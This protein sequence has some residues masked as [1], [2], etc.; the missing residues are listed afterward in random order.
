MTT[1]DYI[2]LIVCFVC[3]GAFLYMLFRWNQGSNPA[4]GKSSDRT[5]A[6]EDKAVGAA[7]LRRK[8]ETWARTH[9]AKVIGP[10]SLNWG[11]KEGSFDFVLVGWFGALGVNCLGYGGTIYGT[12]DEKQWLQ[13][14]NGTRLQFDNPLEAQT[15]SA[16]VL[17]GVLMDGG[18]RGMDVES[19]LVFT[20]PAVELS[21]PRRLNYYS[22]ETF[23]ALLKESRF[24]ADKGVDVEKACQLIEAANTAAKQ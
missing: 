24:A 10:V 21:L 3:V 20:S 18:L 9:D 2:Q 1:N 15:T 23:A 19:A 4:D 12:A 5:P 8:A 11:G 16:R 6:G 17:R 14:K 13:E 7:K 22:N